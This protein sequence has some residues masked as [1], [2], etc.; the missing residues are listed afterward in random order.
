MPDATFQNNV[1]NLDRFYQHIGIHAESWYRYA[2]GPD[3]GRRLNNGDLCLVIGCDK[4]TSWGIAAFSNSLTTSELQFR[5]IADSSDNPELS[6]TWELSGTADSPRI[7]PSR[8][9]PF[10][11]QCL[12]IRHLTFKLAEQAWPGLREPT[13]VE[14]RMESHGSNIPGSKQ[15][16]PSSRIF[17]STLSHVLNLISSFYPSGKETKALSE[18]REDSL[19]IVAVSYA[20]LVSFD[21][22]SLV[23]L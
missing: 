20:I 12:F 3:M 6:Y 2:N 11:N 17:S 7:G 4:T 9:P 13:G 14:I 22:T 1:N 18:R 5:Q 8:R 21:L 10:P 15:S 23:F 16:D 19:E